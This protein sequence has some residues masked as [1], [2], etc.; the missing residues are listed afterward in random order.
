MPIGPSSEAIASAAISLVAVLSVW[1]WHGV[2]RPCSK[3]SWTGV[4]P[5]NLEKPL[6]SNIAGVL[7][8]WLA[9]VLGN[10]SCC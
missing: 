8:F 7:G 1:D 2:P 9:G 3:G 10:E 4:C 6:S 5:G